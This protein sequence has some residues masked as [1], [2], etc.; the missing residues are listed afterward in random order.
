MACINIPI[1]IEES[2]GEGVTVDYSGECSTE[3]IP[4]WRDS[5]PAVCINGESKIPQVDGCGNSRMVLGGEACCI[6]EWATTGREKCES[7]VSYIEEFDGCGAYRWIPGGSACCTPSWVATAATRCLDGVSQQ[8]WVDGCSASE[9]R[10]GGNA[11]PPEELPTLESTRA[12]VMPRYA[13]PVDGWWNSPTDGPCGRGHKA[14]LAEVDTSP[15]AA[16]IKQLA[17][18]GAKITLREQWIDGAPYLGK[19]WP[20]SAGAVKMLRFDVNGTGPEVGYLSAETIGGGANVYLKFHGGRRFDNTIA[21]CNGAETSLTYPPDGSTG[22]YLGLHSYVL[23]P[24][25]NGADYRVTPFASN[26]WKDAEGYHF[27]S[28]DTRYHNDI[29]W[30]DLGQ[31]IGIQGVSATDPRVQSIA[32]GSCGITSSRKVLEFDATCLVKKRKG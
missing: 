5:G 29:A 1:L 21:W 12:Y 30:G 10:A 17:L 14:W 22:T 6:P 2:T 26:L 4:M 13:S 16:A 23:P 24:Q 11:C 7:S 20:A 28:V 27:V 3:C 25:A 19:E 9:W 15:H 18:Q 8:L 31:C 32:I